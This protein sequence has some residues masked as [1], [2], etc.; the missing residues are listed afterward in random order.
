MVTNSRRN[1]GRNRRAVCGGHERAYGLWGLRDALQMPA[2]DCRRDESGINQ[3]LCQPLQLL[4]RLSA[5]GRTGGENRT[6]VLVL[7]AFAI[8]I[9]ISP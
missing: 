1:H 7:Y 8:F 5:D 6:D 3:V 2:V 9:F 4:V